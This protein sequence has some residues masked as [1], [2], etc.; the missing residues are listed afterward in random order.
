MT[1]EQVDDG[2][3]TPPPPP[4]DDPTVTTVVEPTSL[5][6]GGS[7]TAT[8]SLANL[9][10]GGYA[11]TEFTCTYDPAILEVGNIVEG[12]LFGTDAAVAVNG[13][14]S[15]S[16]IL[17]VAGSNGQKAGADGAALTF[18]VTALQIGSSDIACAAKVS[19][20]DGTLT[21]IASTGATLPV[22]ATQG[23]LAGQVNAVKPVTVTLFNADNSEA[24]TVIANADGTFSLAAAAGTYTVTAKAEGFLGAQGSA[25]IISGETLTK[26]TIS[27]LAGDVDGN[28]VIDAFDAMT[29]GLNYNLAAPAAADLNNDGV[30]NVLDLERL[31]ANYHQSGA[32]AWE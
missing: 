22:V 8:V 25:V 7:A 30:I 16:F 3:P 18:N 15:G 26:P 19:T 17:A 10:E 24:G 32:L 21:S 13:P 14:T 23:T 6:V 12:G 1:I 31:A 20:G 4:S 11:S 29:I 9:P 5:A 2:E 27:L 28:G